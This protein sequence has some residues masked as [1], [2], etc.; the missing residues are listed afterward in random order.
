MAPRIVNTEVAN[1]IGEDPCVNFSSAINI[2]HTLVDEELSGSGLSEKRLKLIELLLAAHFAVLGIERGGIVRETFGS[3]SA[4]Y[5]NPNNSLTGFN[6]TRFGQQAVG[7][8]TTGILDSLTD[9]KKRAYF[10]V[11]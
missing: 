4:T 1:L 11:I 10:A 6:S 3:A 7:L 8:D 9:V 2:A 5:A